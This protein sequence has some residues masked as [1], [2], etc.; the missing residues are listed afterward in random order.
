MMRFGD[1]IGHTP[2]SAELEAEF[3]RMAQYVGRSIPFAGV[4]GHGATLHPAA[5]A[6]LEV[7]LAH[8]ARVFSADPFS[9]IDDAEDAADA[10]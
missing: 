9:P 7:E 2:V 3:Q 6:E 10:D 1:S 5:F 8:E 4:Y